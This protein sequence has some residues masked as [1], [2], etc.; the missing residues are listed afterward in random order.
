MAV[1]NQVVTFALAVHAGLVLKSFFDALMRD[2][3]LPL[4]SPLATVEGG[5]SKLVIQV[6]TIKINIGDAIVQTLNLVLAFAVVS[7]V[8]PYIKEYVPIAGRR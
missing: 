7:L 8:M 1:E 2:I 4:L 6:G 5:V 3:V